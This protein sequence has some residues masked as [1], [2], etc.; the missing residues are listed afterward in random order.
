MILDV[1]GV[2][3]S[4]RSKE[5]LREV[6][7][8]AESGEVLGILGHN[9]CGKTTLLKCIN[10]A[11]SPCGGCVE[12]DGDPVGEMSKREIAKKMAVVMQTTSVTF[13]FTVYETVMMGRYSRIEALGGEGE[14]DAKAVY[15]AMAETETVRFADRYIDELSGGERRRV[16][17]ARALAQEPGALLLDEP[18]LHLDINHQFDLME[19][20]RRLA[21]ERG[22]LVVLV[23]HDIVLAARYCDRAIMMRE[24]EIAAAGPVGE[25]VNAENLREIFQIEAD[26][27]HD[28]RFGIGVTIVGRAGGKK[29]DAGREG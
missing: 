22:M 23:T 3:F 20:I 1:G 12:V 17:I 7:F 11:L 27:A 18:T 9:G 13:P 24:G 8:K 26:V 28:E 16:M 5:V 6:E 19:L 2:S 25:I 14:E 21:A 29:R 15:R 10:A 4:Y